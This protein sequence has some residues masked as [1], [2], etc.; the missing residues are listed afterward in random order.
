MARDEI[1]SNSSEELILVDE[2]DREIGH[3]SKADCHSGNGILHRAFSIFVFND[4]DELLLQKRSLD[5]PLWPNYWSNT[6][7]SHPRRGE[8]MDEAVSRR[9]MQELGFDCP[10]EFLYK[11]KYHAQYGAVGAEHEY[12]WVYHGRYSGPVDANV[13]EIAAS[14]F[15]AITALEAELEANPE[16]FTPWFKMEWAHIR[17]NYLDSLLSRTGTDG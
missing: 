3:R 12:C 10:L 5:K 2:L 9:L 1:V 15:L 14:R 16:R 17:H 13:N 6:C 4:D 7:C 8:S 11:F